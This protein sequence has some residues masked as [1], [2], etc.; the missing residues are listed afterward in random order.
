M[1]TFAIYSSKLLSQA[2]LP[3]FLSSF[4]SGMIF[5]FI[6]H[7][8]VHP[9]WNIPLIYFLKIYNSELKTMLL[10]YSNQFE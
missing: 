3:Q 4:L 8:S 10:A 5:F 9:S 7:H 6:I 1:K 2:N